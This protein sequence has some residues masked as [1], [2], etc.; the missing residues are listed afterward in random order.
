MAVHGAAERAVASLGVTAL[1]STNGSQ[2]DDLLGAQFELNRKLGV[3][4]A[5]FDEA[6]DR[7]IEREVLPR[8]TSPGAQAET[9]WDMLSLVDDHEMEVQMTAERLGMQIA[10]D[11]ETEQRELDTFV[12]STGSIAAV[13]RLAIR[14]APR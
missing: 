4:F 14:C 5:G 6:L 8:G 11:C 9:R 3:F 2:R 1:A 10:H 7:R 13:R 12:G